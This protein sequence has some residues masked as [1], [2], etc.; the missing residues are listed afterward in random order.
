MMP[1]SSGE[2]LGMQTPIS[3]FSHVNWV[4]KV[5][6]ILTDLCVLPFQNHVTARRNIPKDNICKYHSPISINFK[7]AI[8]NTG[9]GSILQLQVS[10]KT[11]WKFSVET[12]GIYGT[13]C[14]A[15]IPHSCK[16]IFNYLFIQQKIYDAE[17]HLWRGS[18]GAHW[19]AWWVLDS[20]NVC[21]SHAW[22]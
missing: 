14:T 16:S 12:K 5:D 3:L 7:V 9:I 6:T 17:N 19:V 15:D 22:T 1:F 11:V 2:C 20:Q 8:L 18:R 21:Y 4:G 13:Y 10:Y